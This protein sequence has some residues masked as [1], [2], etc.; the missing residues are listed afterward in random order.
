MASILPNPRRRSAAKPGPGVQRLASIYVAR[1]NTAGI[2]S[3]LRRAPR[4][5]T[6]TQFRQSS[7]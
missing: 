1:A 6:P 3:C 7:P 4:V 2:D 5:L